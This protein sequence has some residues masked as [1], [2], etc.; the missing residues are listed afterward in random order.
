MIMYTISQVSDMVGIAAVTIRSW[1]QR[2]G[3]ITPI[4]KP[5]GHRVYT[6]Q[7]IKD[8]IFLKECI[9][10]KGFSISQ[11]V[12]LLK[13][14]RDQQ[15]YSLDQVEVTSD[16]EF[17]G[18]SFQLKIDRL[19]KL[20]GEYRTEQA[21]TMIDLGFTMYG[22]EM[23]IHKV[24][25]PMMIEVGKRWH[26][27]KLSIGQEHYISQFVLQRCHSF[28]HLFPIDASLPK[29]LAFNPSGENHQVGLLLFSLFLRQRG[30]EVLF[31]GPDTP[32]E[33]ID[34]ILETQP[35]G[36]VC[37]SITNPHLQEAAYTFL[38]HTLK[39]FPH[40]QFTLGGTGFTNVPERYMHWRLAVHSTDHWND[41]YDTLFMKSA[42]Q[43]REK[44]ELA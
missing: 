16:N 9:D 31:L 7:H 43:F 28:Y 6:E 32:Y 41:W 26:S 2:H 11:A 33:T 30:V 38:D 42:D 25:V 39:Q 4:R 3:I 21:K 29:V 20:L 34:Q 8:F 17:D 13:R 35:I 40:M 44:G 5:S 23:M 18:P 27:G 12:S 19:I 15:M 37:I 1:E 22:Y 24:L 36:S 10:E 14:Q